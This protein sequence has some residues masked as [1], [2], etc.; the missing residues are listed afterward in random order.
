MV[1]AKPE[2]FQFSVKVPETITHRKKLEKANKLGASFYNYLQVYCTGYHL[3]SRKSAVY[4]YITIDC[5][6]IASLGMGIATFN[7]YLST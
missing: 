7:I 4:S 6:T 1:K 3:L 2:D 5:I